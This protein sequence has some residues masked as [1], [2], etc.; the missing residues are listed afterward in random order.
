[1]FPIVAMLG[2]FIQVMKASLN[3]RTRQLRYTIFHQSAIDAASILRPAAEEDGRS[4][5]LGPLSILCSAD[6]KTILW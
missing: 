1:M 3:D 2:S 6:K 5:G 4:L